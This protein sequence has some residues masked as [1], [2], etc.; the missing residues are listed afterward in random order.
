[1]WATIRAVIAAMILIA[2]TPTFAENWVLVADQ[3]ENKVYLD[4][5][6][7]ENDYGNRQFNLKLTKMDGSFTVMTATVSCEATTLGYKHMR[8]YTSDG[9]LIG[10]RDLDASYP[11][12]VMPGT[13]A[14]QMLE[15]VCPKY[16]R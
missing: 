16:R 6:S 4:R 7:I 9:E 10:E 11:D 3:G 5:D 13:N 1:M 15:Q 12:L 8:N 2:S 14:F